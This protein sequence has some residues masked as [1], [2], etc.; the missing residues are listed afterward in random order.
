MAELDIIREMDEIAIRAKEKEESFIF[1]TVRVFCNNVIMESKMEISK[2]D[3]KEALLLWRNYDKRLKSDM[4]DMLE[5]LYEQMRQKHE[6]Y[7]NL[8]DFDT[9]YGVSVSMDCLRE[10]YVE[11]RS[12]I[13]GTTDSTDI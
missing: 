3:L 5:K 9:C 1:E 12:E 8:E 13:D 7:F 10:K 2:E 4:A 11:L 6:Y